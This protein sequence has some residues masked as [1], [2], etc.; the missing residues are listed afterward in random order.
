MSRSPSVSLPLPIPSSLSLSVSVSVSL[1]LSLALSL[2]LLPF[3]SPSD[4]IFEDP[5]RRARRFRRASAD[6][7]ARDPAAARRATAARAARGRHIERLT[8]GEQGLLL[9]LSRA[10]PPARALA[11]LP[12][13]GGLFPARAPAPPGLWRLLFTADAF[14]DVYRSWRR[15]RS[16][17]SGV[18]LSAVL[19]GLLAVVGLRLALGAVGA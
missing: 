1:S 15:E 2:S 10:G 9:W 13:V 17:L 3:P 14:S 5:A 7:S 19:A 16:A 4:Q 12:L 8:A 18:A 11:A 6:A